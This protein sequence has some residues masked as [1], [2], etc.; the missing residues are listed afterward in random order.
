MSNKPVIVID[1]GHGGSSKVGGSSPNNAVGPNGL[2]EKN[3]T[4]D[5]ANRV[6]ATLADRA[7]VF[8]TRAGDR[9][10]GLSE[11][12]K[13]A[14]EKNA[15]VFLSIHFNGFS[16]TNVDGTEVWVAKQATPGS[17]TLAKTVL[18]KVVGATHLKD[19]GVREGD[20]GVI[21]P[22]RHAAETSA[23]LLEI[24][25]LSNPAQAKQLESDSY[26]QTIADS[27]CDGLRQH[28]SLA[29]VARS[30][31]YVGDFAAALTKPPPPTP[32]EVAVAVG[33]KSHDDY[34]GREIASAKIFGVK[35]DGEGIRPDFYKKL[36]RAED[37]AKKMI[38]PTPV[39]A[40][41]WGITSIR[42]YRGKELGWHGWGLAIDIDYAKNPYVMHEAGEG[43]LDKLLTPVYERIAQFVLN[44][45]SVIPKTITTG[46][47]KV[48]EMYDRLLEESNAMKTYFK[49][50]PDQALIQKELDKH[51]PFKTSFWK[52]VWGI[53]DRTPSL[54]DLQEIMMRD[55]V[56]LAGEPGP[57]VSGKTYPDAKVVLKGTKVFDPKSKVDVPFDDKGKLASRKPEN[58][59]LTIRKELVLALT[60]EGLRWGAMDFGPE[61]GDVMHFDDA[62]SGSA[63]PLVSK[64]I[65]AKKEL[66]AKAVS[67]AKS[68]GLDDDLWGEQF[69]YAEPFGPG[70][71]TY[72]AADAKWA[73]DAVSPDYRHLG[74]KIDTTPFDF[75]TAHL[76]KLCEANY[77]DV[78]S[79]PKDPRDEVVFALR[80]CQLAGGKESSGG[81]VASVKLT[82]AVP[83]HQQSKCVI[84]V[85]KR[86]KNELAV[87]SGSTVPYWEGMKKQAES[88]SEKICNLLATGR[89]LYTV[90]THRGVE[91]KDNPKL[92][93]M[94]P[95]AI[96][97]QSEVAILRTLDNL[98]YETSDKWDFG[99][100]GDNIHPSR[101]PKPTDSFSSEGCLTIPGGGVF[102]TRTDKHDGL[103]SQFRKAA[104]L[105][106]TSAPENEDGFQFVVILLTGRE[107][108][109]ATTRSKSDLTRLRFGSEGSDV[110]TLQLELSNTA[111]KSGKS[112]KYYAG[113]L[114]GQFS[115]ATAQ[116][117]I[118]WQKDHLGWADGI[119][120]NTIAKSLA[121]D[122][123]K[124]LCLKDPVPLPKT[125]DNN[126]AKPRKLTTEVIDYY[127]KLGEKQNK[128][129][130]KC[131]GKTLAKRTFDE[132]IVWELPEKGEG[133]IIYNLNDLAGK[134]G[135]DKGLDEI[136]TKATIEKII[137][138]AKEWNKTHSDQPL[139]IGD[140]SRPGG[141]DT[142][143][144][145][146]HMDGEAFDMRP[147]RKKNGTGGFTYN[148]TDIYSVDLTKEFIR[149]VRRLYPSTTFHFND[150][151]IYDHKDFKAFVTKKGGHDNHLHVM[152]H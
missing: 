134:C 106:A 114:D 46:K 44:R 125:L 110:K 109:L 32:D 150:E 2:L 85:W 55:Y 84:G 6:A 99:N 18:S 52:D 58:G 50:M 133:Y 66:A 128:G 37:S 9:N 41:D 59:F 68:Y 88:P 47:T 82:E 26:R 97:Q 81:F 91:S 5:M 8:L 121:F 43:D 77:F 33:Y 38:S 7:D 73:A 71:K 145:D 101:H 49:A 75:T 24:S 40:A 35:L 149:L 124:H 115:R 13:F 48:G 152:L 56:T 143:D 102:M 65:A 119:V 123:V 12:A 98:I 72:T 87:F 15:A 96:R 45:A 95:G 78:K 14:R 76:A 100:P 90:G 136:G 139:Q 103:W 19:R 60:A 107:A 86:S 129:E 146:T 89:Y 105:T 10:L 22:S 3:L 126:E 132:D 111:R 113:Q 94:I 16:D 117:Y 151:Q 148:D 131:K 62:K 74:E 83:D 92:K 122:I 118:E 112:G 108:R 67:K 69:D 21:L 27:I 80:G 36:Q 63:N 17:R 140:I 61:S 53:A 30:F 137:A 11:R 28:L 141:I 54:D 23:C 1:P 39:T 34:V 4:L 51:K 135:D 130:I 25:F 147:L 144:H 127:K 70:G 79:N 42:G 57:A 64:V 31:T 104:G 116:A 29:S 142:P 120:T 20:L 93:Y 138:I